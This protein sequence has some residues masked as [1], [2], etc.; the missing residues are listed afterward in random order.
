MFDFTHA[1]VNVLRCTDERPFIYTIDQS[2]II[3]PKGSILPN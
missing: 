3:V 2:K 1:E